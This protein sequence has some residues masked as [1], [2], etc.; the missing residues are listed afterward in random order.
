M[1]GPEQGRDH[2]IATAAWLLTFL[3]AHIHVVLARTLLDMLA[4]LRPDLTHAHVLSAEPDL[5][6]PD[7][8]R[9][10]EV[11]VSSRLD[12]VLALEHSGRWAFS[13]TIAARSRYIVRVLD[14]DPPPNVWPAADGMVT[15]SNLPL[16]WCAK[17]QLSTKPT[18]CTINSAIALPPR[19]GIE[20]GHNIDQSL[21]RRALSLTTVV[22]ETHIHY[23]QLHCMLLNTKY[24]CLIHGQRAAGC[25][26]FL[27]GVPADLDEPK[28]CEVGSLSWVP[29][30]AY[31]RVAR[32]DLRLS[33]KPLN[34]TTN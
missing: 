32:Q 24:R 9:Q 8:C 5:S 25:S 31:I 30:E 34:S 28:I 12:S 21:Q 19:S 14:T 26:L 1:S 2:G 13:L 15:S 33:A 16:P 29:D 27:R 20:F 18:T 23:Q 11:C 6:S 4:V 10:R 17:C 3:A 22:K 7:G